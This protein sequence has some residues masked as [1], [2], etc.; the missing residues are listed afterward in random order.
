MRVAG[1][2]LVDAGGANTVPGQLAQHCRTQDAQANHGHVHVKIYG[3]HPAAPSTS[4]I[5]GHG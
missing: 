3:P 2:E 4:A 1:R 5:I